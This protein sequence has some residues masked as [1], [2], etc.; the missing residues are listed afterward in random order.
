[1]QAET[2]HSVFFWL[3]ISHD[4]SIIFRTMCIEIVV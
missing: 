3:H 4:L 1:M 2:G